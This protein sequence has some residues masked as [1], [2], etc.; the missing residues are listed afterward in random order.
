MHNYAENYYIV[1]GCQDTG[2][3]FILNL[4]LRLSSTSPY[5]ISNN[6]VWKEC[7]LK[8]EKTTLEEVKT[9]QVDLLERMLNYIF[10]PEKS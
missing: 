4:S 3:F 9:T 5:C 2:M 7:V 8:N 6:F 1:A 10:M